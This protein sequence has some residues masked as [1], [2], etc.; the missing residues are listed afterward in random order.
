MMS[1]NNRGDKKSRCGG[2]CPWNWR[3][4]MTMWAW[5]TSLPPKAEIQAQKRGH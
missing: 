2:C 4:I 3:Y 5:P 1:S